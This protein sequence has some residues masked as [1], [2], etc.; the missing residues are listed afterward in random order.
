MAAASASLAGVVEFRRMPSALAP[1]SKSLSKAIRF[2]PISPLLHLAQGSA[3]DSGKFFEP[4]LEN[5]VGRAG[6]Q[7]LDRDVFAERSG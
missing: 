4:I 5:V 1:G 7:P 2:D 6:T 3:H